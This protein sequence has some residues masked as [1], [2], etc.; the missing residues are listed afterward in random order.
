MANLWMVA[1]PSRGVARGFNRRRTE[2]FP[3]ED[4]GSLSQET[5]RTR[6][7]GRRALHLLG[8]PYQASGKWNDATHEAASCG[9]VDANSGL[10]AFTPPSTTS[11][12]IRSK[13]PVEPRRSARRNSI[14]ARVAGPKSDAGH[15]CLE[16]RLP[17]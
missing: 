12:D 4:I 13:H 3:S 10:D 15:Q 5:V 14:L 17:P 7:T 2:G 11:C 1:G 9:N 8:E 16:A 6:G